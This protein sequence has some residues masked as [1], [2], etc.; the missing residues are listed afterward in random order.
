MDVLDKKNV[1][2]VACRLKE[3]PLLGG[4][5]YKIGGF[6]RGNIRLEPGIG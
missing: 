2:L 4:R 5:G 3:V 6:E 1:K